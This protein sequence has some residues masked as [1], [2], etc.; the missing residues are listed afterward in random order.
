MKTIRIEGIQEMSDTHGP[1]TL[2]EFLTLQDAVFHYSRQAEGGVVHAL[3]LYAHLICAY[4][5]HPR[6]KK[7]FP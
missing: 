4:A 7:P 6:C 5:A 1:R 3:A 2:G